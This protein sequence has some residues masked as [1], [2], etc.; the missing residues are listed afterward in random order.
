M[1][2]SREVAGEQDCADQKFPSVARAES[3]SAGEAG[4]RFLFKLPQCDSDDSGVAMQ[5]ARPRGRRR[6]GGMSRVRW[7][8]LC[9]PIQKI[10]GENDS[11]LV[12]VAHEAARTLGAPQPLS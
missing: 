7:R 9:V 12:V 3:E 5:S 6:R 10:V 4:H 2:S 1:D 11:R 8:Y